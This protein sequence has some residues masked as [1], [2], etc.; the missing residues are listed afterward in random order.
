[1]TTLDI[2][3]YSGQQVR[4]VL[5]DG[6]PWFV[7]ADVAN[8]LGLT[9]PSVVAN[10]LFDDDLS[11]AEVIDSMGRKQ[12]ARV[13]NEPG[14]YRLIFQSRKQEAKDFQRWVTHEVLPSIRRT[15]QFG[16]QL[17]SSFAEALEL[18]A[19]EVRKSEALEAK[20]AEDAPKVEAFDRLM[21]AD[22][23]YPMEQVAKIVGTGRTTLYR[24]L[25]QAGV[26]QTGS[27]TPYQKYMH[28]FVLTASTWSDSSGNIHP[29]MT[30]RLRPSGLPFIMSKLGVTAEVAS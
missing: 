12:V 2:F 15:G 27:T 24:K 13:T 9:N 16:S 7:I 10:S 28:H 17:P 19:A 1:M 29:T 4:T 8:V 25:R 11:T 20:V 22:G 14:L 3:T 21:D 5:F 6:E 18:A 30:T 23:F 26:V